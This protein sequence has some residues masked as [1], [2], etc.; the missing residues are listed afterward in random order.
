[1]QD[2]RGP[3]DGT[4][5]GGWRGFSDFAGRRKRKVRQS[6]VLSLL[7]TQV[8]IFKIVDYCSFKPR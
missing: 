4:D 8:K 1:M 2:A 3:L 7:Y 6:Y 5:A